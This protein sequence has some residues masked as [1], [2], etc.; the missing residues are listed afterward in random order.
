MKK[1]LP[2]LVAS[3]LIMI[4]SGVA[5]GRISDTY[6]YWLPLGEGGPDLYFDHLQMKIDTPGGFLS[7]IGYENGI[8]YS[9]PTDPSWAQTYNDGTILITDGDRTNELYF[10][11]YFADEKEYLF[12]LQAWDG[13]TLVDNMDILK[14]AGGWW[15]T[16]AG[17]N[18]FEGTWD[19]QY[20]PA[21][22]AITLAIIGVG[23][24]TSLRRKLI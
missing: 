14:E 4:A 15:N 20:I 8:G 2:A 17:T 12:H 9:Y 16:P 19:A 23:G 21:P 3:S 10:T 13:Y 11:V 5:L 22:A 18:V 1:L 7:P 24:V 6:D